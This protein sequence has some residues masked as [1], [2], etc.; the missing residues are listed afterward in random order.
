MR[1]LK[2]YTY[3]DVIL[4]SCKHTW[5]RKKEADVFITIQNGKISALQEDIKSLERRIA[6]LNRN[7]KLSNRDNA[8]SSD[9]ILTLRRG[10]RLSTL[11]LLLSIVINLCFFLYEILK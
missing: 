8:E 9:L 2:K 5:Y 6:F 3:L 1:E 10:N 11:F 4:T 7:L